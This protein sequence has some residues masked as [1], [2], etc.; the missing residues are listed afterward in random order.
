MNASPWYRVEWDRGDHLALR[1]ALGVGAAL[2]AG[3]AVLIPLLEVLG[4]TS[5][6]GAGRTVPLR[7]TATVADAGGAQGIALSGTSQ[8]EVTFAQPDLT[9]RA[10]LALPEVFSGALLLVVA[11]LLYRIVRTLAVGDPFVPDNARRARGIAVAVLSLAVLRPLLDMVTTGQLV[12]GTAVEDQVS[13]EAT[14]SSGPVLLG[15]LIAALAEVFRRGTRLR[16]DTEG[17]V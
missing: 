1:L 6:D 7:A 10:L 8:G 3:F 4:V 11:Y 5:G 12:L 14:F 16:A 17:L 15:L 13:V 2:V 9:Q